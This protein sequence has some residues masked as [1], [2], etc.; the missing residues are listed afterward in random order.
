MWWPR[1]MK[2]AGLNFCLWIFLLL[3]LAGLGRRIFADTPAPARKPSVLFLNVNSVSFEVAQKL[4]AAGFNLNIQPDLENNPLTWAQA[5]KYNV[6][7]VWA[8]G[9][10]SA[11]GSF[12]PP[13]QQTL[14]SLR[15]FMQAGGGVL[16]IPM[17]GQVQTGL[18]PQESLLKPLGLRMLFDELPVDPQT[19]VVATAWRL[20]FAYTEAITPSPV[21]SGVKGLWYPA[22]DNRPGGESMSYTFQAESTWTTIVKGSPSSS[23]VKGAFEANA[24]TQAGS[25]AHDVPLAAL[26]DV[27]KGRI[28]VLGIA[29][30]YLYGSNA[31]TTLENIVL[32]RGLRNIP[33]GGYQL[34]ENS[35]KWLAAPSLADTALG[36]APDDPQ[37]VEDPN[38][39]KFTAPFSWTNPPSFPPV[40]AAYK[41]VI[42][43]RTS[44]S[45]GKATPDDW[46][47]AAKAQG[48]SYL[49]FLE[50]FSK[51]PPDRFKKLKDDCARLSS[52]QFT[53][54]P[55]FTIDDEIGN[56]YFYFGTTFPYPPRDFLSADGTVFRSRD[57]QLNPKDP[58]T[59][60][61]LAMTTLDYAYTNGN[62]KLTA[63][64]YFFKDDPIPFPNF[65]SNWDAM[66]VVTQ[67][68]GVVLENAKDA[69]LNLSHYGQ[70]P[71]PLAIDLI[72]DPAQLGK[73]PWQ[74]RIY[75]PYGHAP[76][77]GE[78][79]PPPG[80]KIRDYFNNWQLFPEDPVRFSITSGPE[81]EDWSF[82][83]PR[84]YEGALDGDFLWQNYRW[85][86]HGK[87][88][89]PIGLKE[90]AIY[91]GPALFRRF[92]P[93][94]K[95]TFEFQVD[96]THNQ[97][98]TLVLIATDTQGRQAIGGEQIDRNQ[99]M[100]E[101]QCSDRNNQLLYCFT[102]N[103]AGHS[104]H[105]GG[106][107]GSATPWK[108]LYNQ[109]NPSA[110]FGSDALLGWPAF[111]GGPSGDS[112]FFELAGALGTARPVPE[113]VVCNSDRLL[114]SRDLDMGEAN[115][116]HVF[117]DNIQV[118]NLWHTLWRTTPVQ[119]YAVK[120]RTAYIQTNPDSPLG[121]YLLDVTIKLKQ[122]LPNKGFQVGMLSPGL[123]EL[124]TW[125]DPASPLTGR[126]E[127][128]PVSDTRTLSKPFEL[129]DY[130]GFLDTPLGSVAVFPMTPGLQGSLALPMRTN[131]NL[132]LS[133]E[134]SPQKSGEEG[135]ARL[136]LLGLPR[137]TAFTTFL[138]AATTEVVETFYHQFGLDGGTT[139]YQVTPQ[140]GTVL[141]RH[142][143]LDLD[144]KKDAAFSGDL[145]GKLISSLPITVEHLNG[146]WSA[147]LYDRT[148]KKARPLGQFEGK[149]WATVCLNGTD[150][151]FIGQPVVADN[152]AVVI[153]V[154][155]AGES[156]WSIELHNPTDQPIEM[157]ARKNDFFDPFH[158]KTFSE[159][160]TLPP[161]SSIYRQL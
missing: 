52:D 95:P 12:P 33:S 120:R 132:S 41:G 60:G 55:G 77:P 71:I 51:L 11:D 124:W 83:G 43:P 126:W 115:Y 87:V 13:V 20:P 5:Q 79:P 133:P 94:G 42:G 74:S 145:T 31:V 26:R 86:L 102:T 48:L 8:L 91:D 78:A 47:K 37:L 149:A 93:G 90:V 103:S 141:D 50:E 101:F 81:I 143:I 44:Y 161:G 67:R 7:V 128:T 150:D 157:T 70:G 110:I 131:F 21:T 6:I 36:G 99:R 19:S 27:D 40:D 39:T 82:A 24:F 130:F 148:L 30:E 68:D 108:R 85:I 49:V 65:F 32:E 105:L 35:L 69:M 137:Q 4:G 59:R 114:V 147:Y 160:I 153:Q 134:S 1:H 54:I 28:M 142:Y 97:Q 10:T 104:V 100:E 109:V 62:F 2:R 29:A 106:N 25:F 76:S 23:T 140:T 151:L 119:E 57:P 38:K 45:S 156:N 111:D 96:M 122:D 17:L 125:R 146:N 64:N 136:L 58:Y 98:H 89:S 15:Q 154:T 127:E 53:A 75:F 117:T 61:Q 46:V 56:H 73:S 63:G 34:L 155:Q 92:L 72:S 116:E 16:V 118:A 139:G 3:A 138:P 80:S 66:G 9:T 22:M 112:A 152:P 14:A 129:G 158:D 88:T 159:K 107:S 113:P 123:S 135:H 84:D 121:V 144:G 18:P